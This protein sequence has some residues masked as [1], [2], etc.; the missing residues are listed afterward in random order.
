MKRARYEDEEHCNEQE[1]SCISELQMANID[2]KQTIIALEHFDSIK[3][4]QNFYHTH[5]DEIKQSFGITDWREA[6]N[7]SDTM[8][9]YLPFAEKNKFM[10]EVKN[11]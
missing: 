10:L 8:F 2:L 1:K 7:I 4:K 5:K 11:P 6:R 9:D 3:A